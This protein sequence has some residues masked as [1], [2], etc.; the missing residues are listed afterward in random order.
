[1]M[2]PGTTVILCTHNPHPGRLRRTLEGLRTQTLP[3]SEWDFLLVDNASSSKESLAACD[4]S[5]HPRGIRLTEPRLG[6]TWARVAGI[7]A[8][9]R[10]ELVFVDDDNVLDP[11]YLEIAAGILKDTPQ[12]VACGGRITP[13]FEKA[14]D[15]WIK[16]VEWLLAL[17]YFG[18]EP[19][20]ASDLSAGYPFFAPI[21]AGLV[22]R[23]AELTN[24]LGEEKFLSDR[25]GTSLSSGGDSE[26]VLRLIQA[27]GAVGYFP[28]LHLTHLIPGARLQ[29]DYLARLNYQS[30]KDWMRLLTRHGLSPR[31]D[32][33]RWTVPLRKL[34]AYFGCRAWRDE[35]SYIRWSGVCGSV[36]GLAD[37]GR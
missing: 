34:K 2:K 32:V 29:R 6:L 28:Q 21:G 25:M 12:L 22:V 9:E 27:G 23:R 19:L 7:H 1:M 24:W 26:M 14:P 5:W 4:V 33:T 35:P 30:S 37:R 18:E 13:E 36:E 15:P 17:R 16:E 10:Q 11:H 31:R 20:V 8:A 3:L